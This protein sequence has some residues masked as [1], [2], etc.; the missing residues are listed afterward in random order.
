[1]SEMA[2][3]LERLYRRVVM[4]VSAGRV[5]ATGDA[6]SVQKLQV[7]LRGDQEIRDGTPR[8]AEYG[9]TSV[10][11]PGCD[12]VV[13]FA[14]GDRSEGIIVATGDQRYRLRGLAPGEVSLYDDLGQVVTLKRSGIVVNT[15]LN[16]TVTAGQTL[17]LVAA[18]VQ[19]HATNSFRW[20][21]N[22]HGQHWT[23]TSIN[24]YPIGETAGTANAIS[25][26][27]IS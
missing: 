3:A 22:G 10:P 7:Q 18:D 26:P 24:T 2:E 23:P 17:R 20:D 21:V 27:E 14:G 8:I 13:I 4:L 11:Q 1:M 25:P 9:F 6:G 15:S 5:T 12:A 19:I 16:V